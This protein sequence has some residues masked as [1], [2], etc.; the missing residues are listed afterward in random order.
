VNQAKTLGVWFLPEADVQ[1]Q[2]VE[3]WSRGRGEA[4]M[5]FLIPMFGT[6]IQPPELPPA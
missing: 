6:G 2:A 5:G 3:Q 4:L 1:R